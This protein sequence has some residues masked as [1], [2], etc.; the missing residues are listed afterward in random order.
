MELQ[1]CAF[2]LLHALEV[3]TDPYQAFKDIDFAFLIGAKPRGLG[4]ERKDLLLENGKI[5]VEQGR[6]LNDVAKADAKIM[7]VGNPCNTD[8]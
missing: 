4:M 5:F 3:S 1:D 6:A 8:F 7:V 2:P